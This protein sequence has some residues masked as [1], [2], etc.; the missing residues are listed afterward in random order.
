MFMRLVQRWKKG[1]DDKSICMKNPTKSAWL[2]GLYTN[3]LGA[4]IERLGYK[5]TR[6]YPDLCNRDAPDDKPSLIVFSEDRFSTLEAMYTAKM[7]YPE[8]L[9]ISLPAGVEWAIGDGG[10]SFENESRTSITRLI[11]SIKERD[12]RWDN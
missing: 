11:N 9:L 6:L 1:G 3:D 2:I 10:I 5:L 7:E 12:Y 4:R 8:A